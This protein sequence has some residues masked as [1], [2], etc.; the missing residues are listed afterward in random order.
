MPVY[1]WSVYNTTNSISCSTTTIK[2]SSHIPGVLQNPGIA[3]TLQNA[4]QIPSLPPTGT[5]ESFQHITLKKE[6]R[7]QSHCWFSYTNC[8]SDRS[9]QGG[10][11]ET[12]TK[13]S[14]Q[15]QKHCCTST[16]C[17]TRRLKLKVAAEGGWSHSLSP[18]GSSLIPFNW[19]LTVLFVTGFKSCNLACFWPC[20]H[21]ICKRH[22]C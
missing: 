20:S 17:C 8:L 3:N 13:L 22:L 12:T 14:I 18:E 9:D 11:A 2:R 7:C 5:A 16:R 4:N 21:L 1:S 10:D 15:Q 6:R 19:K